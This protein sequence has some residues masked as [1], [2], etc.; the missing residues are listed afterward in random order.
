MEIGFG[1][2]CMESGRL[3][4][5]YRLSEWQEANGSVTRG[6]WVEGKQVRSYD[7]SIIDENV[8]FLQRDVL[9]SVSGR[10]EMELD[11]QGIAFKENSQ[12]VNLVILKKLNFFQ[13]PTIELK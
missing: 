4:I 12:I 8:K 9:I 11:Q 2:K 5:I 7:R 10:H 1:T 6:E 3:Y 13:V